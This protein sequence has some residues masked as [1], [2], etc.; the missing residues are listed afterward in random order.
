MITRRRLFG[1]IAGAAALG[2]V[3][4]ASA[5]GENDES[6]RMTPDIDP[7]PVD[8][9]IRP[10]P[11]RVGDILQV[12]RTLPAPGLDQVDPFIMLDHFDFAMNV[13]ERGGLAPHP[14]RGLETVTVIFEGELEHGDSLGNRGL[15]GPGDVQWMTAGSG[16]VHEENPADSMREKGGRVHGVQL[17]VNLPR[18]HRMTKPRYQDRSRD[19]IAGVAS[20]GISIRVIAGSALGADSSLQTHSPMALIDATLQPNTE[21]VFAFPEG[22]TG[23]VQGVAGLAQVNDTIVAPKHLALLSRVG[24]GL[25]LRNESSSPARILF[26]GGLPIAEP[27]VRHGPFVLDAREDV[28]AAILDYQSGKMGRVKNP[29]YD[30]VRL[31]N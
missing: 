20:D 5:R 21:G 17:W 10:R 11:D 8:R 12:Q 27:F 31:Q 9:G 25:V 15:I 14:H 29:T 7:R 2:M 18:A 30:R 19:Q 28:Q 16:I 13:G 4:D 6:L 1:R 23:F 24:S 22:W 3:R 26:G